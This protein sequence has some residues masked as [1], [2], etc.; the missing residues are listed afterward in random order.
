[1][2]VLPYGR[3]FD[4]PQY[5]IREIPPGHCFVFAASYSTWRH[6]VLEHGPTHTKWA[7]L[8]S[9]AQGEVIAKTR[10]YWVKPEN[11]TLTD[12]WR[13]RPSPKGDYS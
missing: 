6:I 5:T 11:P 10:V 2:V 12:E 13:D 9:P 8:S 1:V 7:S 4:D 3:Q